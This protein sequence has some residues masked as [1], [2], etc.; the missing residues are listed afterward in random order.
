M[1][2]T[3]LDELGIEATIW[4]KGNRQ[5]A[6]LSLLVLHHIVIKPATTCLTVRFVDRNHL[7]APFAPTVHWTD[8]SR[9]TPPPR[10]TSRLPFLSFLASSLLF[11]LIPMLQVKT[12]S[13]PVLGFCDTFP[14]S[15][16]SHSDEIEAGADGGLAPVD[17]WLVQSSFPYR[18]RETFHLHLSLAPGRPVRPR[19]ALETPRRALLL[20]G[21]PQNM[22][23]WVQVPTD[24]SECCQ[25]YPVRESLSMDGCWW[26]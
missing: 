10:S 19:G 7:S 3:R 6:N 14:L 20:G 11:S 18:R 8:D 16:H 23:V 22:R 9:P 13:G 25:T 4:S 17:K 24:A 2:L 15:D 1:L 21:A 12:T 26:D 5:K